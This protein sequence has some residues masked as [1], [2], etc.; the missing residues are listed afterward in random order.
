MVHFPF[1]GYG[2]PFLKWSEWW[3]N[4]PLLADLEAS[5][6]CGRS[7][8]LNLRVEKGQTGL[9]ERLMRECDCKLIFGR[10]LVRG[11]GLARFSGSY[12]RPLCVRIAQLNKQRLAELDTASVTRPPHV[13]PRWAVELATSLDYK[14]CFQYRFSRSSHINLL[15]E[16]ALKTL[17]KRLSRCSADSRLL[18][19]LDS[20]VCIGANAKGRS[21]SPALNHL[22]SGT[23][24]YVLGG[25]LYLHLLHVPSAANSADD[26]SRFVRLRSAA[27]LP[28]E[29]L[30]KLKR[31]DYKAFELVLAAD[32]LVWPLSG[33]ARLLL[34]ASLRRLGTRDA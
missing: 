17:C 2:T 1:C 29:W 19:L 22:L 3:S 30:E 15:E 34:L 26:P 20:K 14:L 23:L 24:P 11:E 8:H 18:V 28:P 16:R 7:K 33:W 27:D 9:R 5:C 25:N 13:A 32:A 10:E 4:N 6:V 31:G 21:S 12:P